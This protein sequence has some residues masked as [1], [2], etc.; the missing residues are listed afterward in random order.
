MSGPGLVERDEQLLRL[1]RVLADCVTQRGQ[2]VLVEAPLGCGKT[3]LLRV[4]AERAEGRGFRTLS[5]AC[6][7]AERTVPFGLVHQLFTHTAW[8]EGPDAPRRAQ[9]LREL[10]AAAPDPAVAPPPGPEPAE[11][12]RTY[13]ELT[14]VL[15]RLAAEEPVL[16]CVD[17]LRHADQPSV[18]CLLHLL[19]WL[20][21]A[22]RIA[23][24]LTDEP[25]LRPPG[26]RR[27]AELSG[28]PHLRRLS[29]APL[30]E[31]ATRHLT[32]ER[33]GPQAARRLGRDVHVTAGGNPSLLSALIEDHRRAGRGP[34]PDGYGMALVNLLHRAEPHLAR[35]VRA[36]AVLGD[37]AAPE[38][39]GR[40]AGCG[41]ATANQTV[42]ALD[43]AGLLVGRRFRHPVA[44]T[45]VLDDL[46]PVDRGELH[47]RAADLLHERGAPAQRVAP[48]LVA[49]DHVHAPWTTD[50]LSE[51]AGHAWIDDDLHLAA[52]CLRLAHRSCADEPARATL[53][54]RLARTEWQIDPAL[55]TRHFAP[56]AE[57]VTAR[58]L[59]PADA[60]VLVK[61][62]LWHGRGE[63]AADLLDVLRARTRTPGEPGPVAARVPGATAHGLRGLEAWLAWHHPPLAGD[64][65][66]IAP[67]ADRRRDLVTPD[68][69]PLLNAI[70]VLT[71]ALLRNRAHKAADRAEQ[72]LRD[73]PLHRRS[74]WADDAVLLA[75]DVL[76][77]SD[78]LNSA[79]GWCDWLSP[80]AEIE[81]TPTLRA[82]LTAARAHAALRLGAP[83]DAVR[84]ARA[85]LT[86]LPP[87][88]WGVAVGLPLGTLILA[89][90]R[91]G[92]FDEAAKQLTRPVPE[93]LFR[94]SYGTAYLYARGH[95]HLATD[96]GHA[97]LA[98]FL[99]CG[100]LLCEGGLDDVGLLP[101]R[102]D[103]AE[104]WLRLGNRSQARRLAH[105]QLRRP[106]PGVSRT[107]GPAL[108][109][110]AAVSPA[111]RRLPLL[112]EAIDLAESADDRYEQAKVLAELSRAHHTGK[113]KRRARLLLRQ[114]LHLTSTCGMRQLEQELLA[115]SA[116]FG[117]TGPMADAADGIASLTS[118]ER[119][120]AA[121]AVLGHTNREIA[122]RLYITPSTV[123]QHLT[124]VY[125]KL[126]IRHRGE[127]PAELWTGL[128]KTG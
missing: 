20:G 4:L 110:L 42:S 49:A 92:E 2:A 22:R 99:T 108:R 107:R 15:A 56:L 84:D 39:V 94:S 75:L 79:M 122:A 128:R 80:G 10:A 118:S 77:L 76:L 87:K 123:E 91:L 48:H 72:V 66:G 60:V 18:G 47:R 54:A 58:R 24:V 69:D 52:D 26:L 59:R 97:A 106:G 93:S 3:E 13:R 28:L 57:A 16:I 114:A 37:E 89:H 55:A 12:V 104:A 29:L 64:R 35:V 113:N 90:T 43:A 41:T 19:R 61:H 51:A 112:G 45:A 124:R 33:L 17:D 1:D 102:T 44:R 78:R 67:P 68:A 86:L 38:E 115:V 117:G 109:V 65:R 7:P 126:K 50:V 103:A 62:L 127:L 25:A 82:C 32:A 85:A 8:P 74:P 63:Q 119:R 40:L 27:L 96:H 111:G 71:D 21:S 46:G 53:R 31:A 6:S 100:E 125:R 81:G 30:S 83:A 73:L 34:R 95:Y 36:L 9:L 70:A 120:V 88:S 101:W 116:E 5:V 121:L 14:Q 98:D 105:E 23:L 11:I